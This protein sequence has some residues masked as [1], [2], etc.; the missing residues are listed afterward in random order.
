MAALKAG[1]KVQVTTRPVT[2]EDAKSGLYFAYFGGLIGTVDR[3]YDDGSVCVEIDLDSL[4]KEMRDR[5]LAMQA[6]EKKRWLD[7]LSD[8]A[9][10]RLSAEQQQ[11]K[12]S[13]KILMSG[14]DLVGYKGDKPQGGASGKAKASQAGSETGGKGSE[15]A[16]KPLEVDDLG[17]KRPT[18]ADLAAAEEAFL[19]S[20]E[21]PK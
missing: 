1:D 12:I 13:Y 18:A 21:M 10:R 5:H 11:L 19:K 9:R 3:V 17:D 15:K 14:K 2:S 16:P 7:G 8:E 20:R 6:A 4:G